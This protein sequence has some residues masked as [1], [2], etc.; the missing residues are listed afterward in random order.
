MRLVG[1]GKVWK[2]I[3]NVRLYQHRYDLA[4]FFFFFFRL[5]LFK[6]RKGIFLFKERYSN[7]V[8]FGTY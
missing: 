8:V 2:G 6:K 4:F 1:R 5:I 3:E 7:G